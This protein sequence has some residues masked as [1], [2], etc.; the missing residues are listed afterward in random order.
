MSIPMYVSHIFVM[1]LCDA[2]LHCV[3]PP[4]DQDPAQ[5]A[6]VQCSYSILFG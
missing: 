1:L 6:W 2:M 3:T 4:G 5:P